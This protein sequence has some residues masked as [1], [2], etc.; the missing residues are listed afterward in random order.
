MKK[1]NPGYWFRGVLRSEF[2]AVTGA[3]LLVAREHYLAVGGLDELSFAVAFNDVDFCLRLAERGYRNVLCAY[4]ELIHHESKSRGY[5]DTPEKLAR[6]N[7]E[8]TRLRQRWLHWINDDPAYNPNLNCDTEF[9]GHDWRHSE[10]TRVARSAFN[11]QDDLDGLSQ[12]TPPASPDLIALLKRVLWEPTLGVPI[13]VVVGE[14][15]K[16]LVAWLA[17]FTESV[18]VVQLLAGEAADDRMVEDIVLEDPTSVVLCLMSSSVDEGLGTRL[19]RLAWYQR[20]AV[21]QGLKEAGLEDTVVNQEV[22]A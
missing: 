1:D 16:E 2:T 8:R 4:A 14:G 10:R 15:F 3:C 9:F 11:S 13:V 22:S 20:A 21:Y 19:E 6:F 7:I 12:L 18:Q 17:H 5:E